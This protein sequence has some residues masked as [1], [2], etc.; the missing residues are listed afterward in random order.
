MTNTVKRLRIFI[1]QKPSKPHTQL[2][3]Q[4]KLHIHTHQPFTQVPNLQTTREAH[5]VQNTHTPQLQPFL[6]SQP[7]IFFFNQTL[8]LRDVKN[9]KE[10]KEERLDT[11]REK[12]ENERKTN[13]E[14]FKS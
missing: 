9:K 11:K 13:T 4:S 14:T 2:H 12:E 7:L 8:I 1:K 5:T 6:H 3:V 10:K